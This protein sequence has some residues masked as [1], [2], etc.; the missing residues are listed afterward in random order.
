MIRINSSVTDGFYDSDRL[1][2]VVNG[3]SPN[4]TAYSLSNTFL[5]ET[6]APYE[7]RNYEKHCRSIS[8]FPTAF[9]PLAP[10]YE[11]FRTG[12]MSVEGST[13]DSKIK[14]IK[15][16]FSSFGF[17]KAF[18]RYYRIK[19]DDVSKISEDAEPYYNLLDAKNKARFIDLVEKETVDASGQVVTDYEYG[20]DSV[21]LTWSFDRV[22]NTPDG[23][24]FEPVVWF[25]FPSYYEMPVY[26]DTTIAAVS[27][28]KWLNPFELALVALQNLLEM[29]GENKWLRIKYGGGIGSYDEKSKNSTL[30]VSEDGRYVIHPRIK[31]VG[32]E[33]D[34]TTL[35][36]TLASLKIYLEKEQ[37]IV[38]DDDAVIGQQGSVAMNRLMSASSDEGTSD[39]K[40]GCLMYIAWLIFADFYMNSWRG[41]AGIKDWLLLIGKE[42]VVDALGK[43]DTYAVI[44]TGSAPILVT[45]GGFLSITE[46]SVEKPV[47]A[48]LLNMDTVFTM[49]GIA[50]TDEL[51]SRDDFEVYEKVNNASAYCQRTVDPGYAYAIRAL[52][53]N[54]KKN[55][56][57]LDDYDEGWVSVF[58][59]HA[60]KEK[61][62]LRGTGR[63]TELS[64]EDAINKYKDAYVLEGFDVDLAETLRKTVKTTY[65][66]GSGYESGTATHERAEGFDG[67]EIKALRKLVNLLHKSICDSGLNVSICETPVGRKSAPVLWSISEVEKSEHCVRLPKK[68]NQGY[69]DL[70]KKLAE[71]TD[72]CLKN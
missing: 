14:R 42:N 12:V 50:D 60:A 10:V 39:T 17:D 16:F 71:V 65:F 11:A 43:L 33:S 56:S 20:Y 9:E 23:K 15:N 3:E 6:D 36:D 52:T 19:S 69:A 2:P 64:W 7:M 38:V 70:D 49:C 35:R 46:G 72:N 25:V 5:L 4:L 31:V 41:A 45:S 40:Y 29:T 63:L 24:G 27:L 66:A 48:E 61:K 1:K 21:E 34:F 32:M 68:V 67:K 22:I 57:T 18:I 54:Y 28:L 8:Q 51:F 53:Y 55:Y 58:A 59:N 37:E 62:R 44:N 26:K 13:D 30:I 47:R